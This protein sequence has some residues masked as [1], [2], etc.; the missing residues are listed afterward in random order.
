MR[1]DVE[2]LGTAAVAADSAGLQID[3]PAGSRLADLWDAMQRACPA[4]RE[5]FDNGGLANHYLASLDGREFCRNGQRKLDDIQTVLIM[6][7][8]AG[9]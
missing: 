7:V 6:S 1:I 8:D 9:G 4:T 5:L 3:L 2:L